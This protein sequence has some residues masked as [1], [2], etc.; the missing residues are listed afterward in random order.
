MRV[1]T[2]MVVVADD[3]DGYI[4]TGGNSSRMGEPK[5]LLELGGRN[6]VERVAAALSP[7]VRRV[8]TVGNSGRFRGIENIPDALNIDGDSRSSLRGLAS[9]LQHAETEWIFV[10][11]CDMPFVSTELFGLIASKRKEC[12]GAV[13]PLCRDG[14]RQPLCALYRVVACRD[15][16]S[17][18]ISDGNLSLQNLLKR[19]DTFQIPFQDMEHLS[20]SAY[21][22]RNLNTPQEFADAKTIVDNM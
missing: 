12:F 8:Y 15:K 17:A 1:E 4:L 7:Q 9:A 10:V 2:G 18:A 16:C 21:F 5:G 20:R 6:L 19:V 11:A 14:V 13:V 22:F 3:I